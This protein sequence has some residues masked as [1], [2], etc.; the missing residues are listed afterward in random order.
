MP[1]NPLRRRTTGED[2]VAMLTVVLVAAIMTALGLAV[3]KTAILNLD[4]AGRDRVASGALGAAEAGVAGA[5]TFL[6]GDGVAQ[7]CTTCTTTYNLINP[8]TV[9]YPGGGK[10]V[11]TIA[12]AQRYAPPTTRVGK[13]VIR[14]VGTSGSGP[15]KRTIEQSIDVKPFDFPLGVYTQGKMNFGGN[16]SLTRESVFSGSCI[17][18]REKLGFQADPAD[19]KIDDAYNGVPAGAHSASYIKTGSES[20][21]STNL[22]QV[23]AT[24][25]RAIHQASTCNTTFWADQDALGGPFTTL[26]GGDFCRTRTTGKGDYDVKGSGFS[27]DTLRDV[28]GFVPRGLTDEQ[29]ALLKTKAKANGTWFPAGVNPVF[30]TASAIPGNPG[31]NPIIYIEDQNVSLT[32]QLNS[33]AYTSDPGCTSLHPSVLFIIERG[34]LNLSSGTSLSGNLFVPDSEIAFSGGASL[35]G[36]MFSKDLKFVGSGNVGLN[37]CIVQNTNGGILSISKTRFR[38]LDS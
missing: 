16:V 2:G 33:Y 20:V 28:Y 9:V 29:F 34:S 24:D 32:N 36:T 26:T 30:P 1:R 6:R 21:C 35:I 7:I 11:V 8:A 38:Q 19:G 13:Y 27:L 22:A 23:K 3:T 5:I 25:N 31:F 17:E 18:S 4:N 12:V 14:S 37:E 10:A 15:G